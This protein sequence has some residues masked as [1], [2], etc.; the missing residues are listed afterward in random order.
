MNAEISTQV[1]R[2]QFLTV[3]SER[4]RISGKVEEPLG[5]GF[6]G[7]RLRYATLRPNGNGLSSPLTRCVETNGFIAGRWGACT[8]F[9]A[10]RYQALMQA[11]SQ[12]ELTW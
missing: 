4:S 11:L 8:A 6:A 10:N 12:E 9:R 7:L 2:Q 3:C 1:W 5:G